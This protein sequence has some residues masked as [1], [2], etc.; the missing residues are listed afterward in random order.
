ML[1]PPERNFFQS[2]PQ[3]RKTANQRLPYTDA[4]YASVLGRTN[5]QGSRTVVERRIKPHY[6]EVAEKAAR[7]V[8]LRRYRRN[9]AFGLVLVAA[10]ILL[11]RLLRTNPKWIFPPGWW[12]P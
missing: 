4:W 10:A 9:Q 12:R 3:P 1:Y 2:D 5:Q 6:Q 8:E 7:G 11:F